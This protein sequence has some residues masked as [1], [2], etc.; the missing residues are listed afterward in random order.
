[1]LGEH[2]N[3]SEHKKNPSK[4][5]GISSTRVEDRHR[6]RNHGNED[7]REDARTRKK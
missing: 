5:K 6:D 7:E 1:M 2:P 4:G 3:R